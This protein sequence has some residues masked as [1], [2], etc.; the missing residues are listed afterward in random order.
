M[1]TGQIAEQ[2][3]KEYFQKKGVELIKKPYSEYGYDFRDKD[4]KL[5]IEVKGTTARNITDAQFHIFTNTEYEKARACRKAKQDYQIHLV[6]GIGGDN[7]K[8]YKI[9][10]KELLDKGRPVVSWSL[11]LKKDFRKYELR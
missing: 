5:F 2:Y 4:S 9:P 3:V 6:T 10:G 11:S 7:I 8:H 1:N